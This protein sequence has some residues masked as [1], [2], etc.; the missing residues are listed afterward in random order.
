MIPHLSAL[1][2]TLS[3][4]L[5]AADLA[6]VIIVVAS[7]VIVVVAVLGLFVWA[8]IQDG[9]EEKALRAWRQRRK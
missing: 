1:P 8:A 3:V 6:A 4:M 7:T 9:R 5:V 2:S